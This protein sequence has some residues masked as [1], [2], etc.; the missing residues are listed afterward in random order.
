MS[1]TVLVPCHKA[2]YLTGLEEPQIV[3]TIRSLKSQTVPPDRIIVLINNCKDDAPERARA[4]GAEVEMVPPNPDKKAGA[5]NF[6]LDANLASLA[7]SDLVMV[8]DADSALNLD[9]LENARHYIHRGYHAVGGV[10]LG[11]EGGGL[12]GMFQRNEYARYAR[13]VARKAGRTLVLTGTATVFTAQCLKDVVAGRTSGKIPGTGA[14]SHVYDTKALTEDNEL[15]YALLHLGYKIIAPPECGLKT[16][17]METWKSLRAQRFRWKRGAIENNHHY[18]ITTKTAKYWF[19]QWWGV[20]GL[21]ATFLYL[22]TL[23]LA[24][25]TGSI[26]IHILWIGVTVVYI[27][28]RIVTVRARGWKQMLVGGALVIEMPYDL[29]LQY[30]QAKALVAAAFHTKK[31]W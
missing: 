7:N 21:S 1:L 28:E 22:L 25:T 9:F 10:F 15:T 29:M 14:V 17:V 16:E 24:V 5:L 23:A 30:V 26:Q 13:D 18:G 27:L 3:E 4:A 12:V 31:N 8:M 6:W 2:G 20:I 11:K 19:L